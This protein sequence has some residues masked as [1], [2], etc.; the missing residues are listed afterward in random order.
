VSKKQDL[1]I[2]FESFKNGNHQFF[3]RLYIAYF[4]KLC[5]YSLNYISDKDTIQDL[6]QDVFITLWTNKKKIEITTSLK[7]YLYKMVYYKIM[8]THRTAKKKNDLLSSYY[9]DALDFV[10]ESDED[11]L[12]ER[13]N[14]LENCIQELPEKCKKVFIA[15]KITNLKNEQVT[16]QLNI[17]VK[18]MEGHITK[19]LKFIRNCMN[20][21]KHIQ[22]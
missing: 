16:E 18:T 9:K 17:S 13:L 20:Q 21:S 1:Y 14:K 11:Y 5:V 8:D 22:N 4:E 19:A 15:K 6:V 3:E 7:S 12:A 2:D 10:I